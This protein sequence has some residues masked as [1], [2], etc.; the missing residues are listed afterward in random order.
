[1]E[2]LETNMIQNNHRIPAEYYKNEFSG[3]SPCPLVFA[4]EHT[5]TLA[6]ASLISY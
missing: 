2:W 4:G 6:Q 1:M 5:A 3:K